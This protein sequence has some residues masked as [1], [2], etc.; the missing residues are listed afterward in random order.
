MASEFV[1]DPGAVLDYKFDWASL[2]NGS[3]TSN[4]LATGELLASGTVTASAGLTVGTISL[5]SGSTCVSYWLSGGA[6]GSYYDVMCHIETNATPS[7][8]DERTV[9]VKVEQ[10]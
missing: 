10:K 9:R 3:G 1:K 4:W 2:T 7:R 6:V 5:T 8:I